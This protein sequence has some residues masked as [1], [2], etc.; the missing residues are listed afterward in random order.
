M[1][2][3]I[4]NGVL[5]AGGAMARGVSTPIII[6]GLRLIAGQTGCDNIVNWNLVNRLEMVSR[7]SDRPIEFCLPGDT[8][9]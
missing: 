6:G 7:N 2:T 1:Y 5:T 3:N 9:I 4:R 8:S